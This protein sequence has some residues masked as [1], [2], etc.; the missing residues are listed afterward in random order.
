M[1]VTEHD[2]RSVPMLAIAIAVL[3]GLAAVG[4]LFVWDGG[5]LVSNAVSLSDLEDSEFGVVY[6]EEHNMFGVA[7]DD[8]DTARLRGRPGMGMP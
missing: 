4:V 3:V 8:R 7:S 2:R 1:S 6:L 5:T